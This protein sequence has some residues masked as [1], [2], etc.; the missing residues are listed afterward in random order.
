MNYLLITVLFMIVIM[1]CT[2]ACLHW[3]Q[4]RFIKQ[5]T[6]SLELQLLNQDSF[7]IDSPSKS[8]QPHINFLHHF[9]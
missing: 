4:H 2:I 7:N 3:R 8:L 6:H 9:H 5:L 1:L